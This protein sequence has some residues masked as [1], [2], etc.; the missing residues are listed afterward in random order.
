MGEPRPTVLLSRPRA[1]SE[2]FARALGKVSDAP[3]II[4]PVIEIEPVGDAVSA[5]GYGAVLFTSANAVRQALPA[6]GAKAYCVGEATA[7]AARA[8]GFEAVSAGGT[9]EDLERR[10]LAD[11]PGGPLL[12]LR[13]AHVR[14][15]LAGRLGRAGMRADEAVVYRQ[16]DVAL[17]EDAKARAAAAPRLVAPVFSPRSAARLS[18]ELPRHADLTVIAISTAAADRWNAEAARIVVARAASAQAMLDAV[19]AALG[20]DSPC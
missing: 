11:L 6:P 18:A 9:A 19:L 15:D 5:E 12:H 16:T 13:G 3:V 4:A 2:R 14:G 7:E 1:A 17:S 20:P 8:A 10:L